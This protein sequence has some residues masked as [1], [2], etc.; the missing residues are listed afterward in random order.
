MMARLL[1][2]F[3]EKAPW[4]RTKNDSDYN[5]VMATYEKKAEIGKITAEVQT[6]TF[7]EQMFQ[8]RSPDSR[9]RLPAK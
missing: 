8:D 9:P 3:E 5:E 1:N 4:I 2:W 7:L 6:K